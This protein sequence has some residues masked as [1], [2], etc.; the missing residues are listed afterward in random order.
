[1][2]PKISVV[3]VNFNGKDIVTTS[4]KAVF[5]QS[6]KNIEVIVVDNNSK[7]GSIEEIKKF[8]KVKLVQNKENL[9][10]TGINSGLK[11]CKGKYI[12][13]T[14]NDI[15]LS[16]DALKHLVALLEKNDEVG[17]ASPKIV[18]YFDKNLKS[19]GTWLSRSF[20]NGHFS[21]SKD[22]M[23]E[24]PTNG[25]ALIRKSLV[26]SFGY[27][28][29][30]D[31]F[32]YAEDV[33]LCLRT[34]LIG[35]TVVHVPNAILYHMHGMTVKKQPKYHQTF[36]LEKNLLTTYF[37]IFNVSTILLFFPFVLAMR[38]VAIAKDIISLNFSNVFARLGAFFYVLFSIPSIISKRSKLQKMRKKPDSFILRVFSEKYLFSKKKINV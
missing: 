4:L 32:I 29:D 17:I 31:Y 3:M 37:K 30:S 25:V 12:F 9:G 27:L 18:N 28:F 20:Y 2:N 19:C 34:R 14:N 11:H 6:Y 33:D 26:D 38:I 22:F 15:S 24:I 13:F 36:R 5:S 23:K 10:Y 16:K 35:K 21:C 1:M 7:D 8:K